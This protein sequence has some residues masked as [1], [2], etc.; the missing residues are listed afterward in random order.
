MLYRQSDQIPPLLPTSDPPKPPEPKAQHPKVSLKTRVNLL[1]AEFFNSLTPWR[2]GSDFK[3]V[4][5]EQLL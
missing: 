1:L 2:C 3:S 5:F 4:I